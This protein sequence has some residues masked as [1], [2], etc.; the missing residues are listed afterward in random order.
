MKFLLLILLSF[1]AF[2]S[3]VIVREYE[4]FVQV[5]G[6]RNIAEDR[7][8]AM[9]KS[10]A[11]FKL[12]SELKK[13]VSVLHQ[14]SDGKVKSDIAVK[15]AAITGEELLNVVHVNT[16][17]IH[18]TKVVVRFSYRPVDLEEKARLIMKGK[19]L[20][21]ELAEEKRLTN[22][23]AKQVLSQN[24]V[25]RKVKPVTSGKRVHLEGLAEQVQQELTKKV[26]DRSGG[27]SNE[28]AEFIASYLPALR[29]SLEVTY[30]D[31]VP[32]VRGSKSYAVIDVVVSIPEKATALVDTINLLPDFYRTRNSS[33]LY[34]KGTSSKYFDKDTRDVLQPFDGQNLTNIELLDVGLHYFYGGHYEYLISNRVDQPTRCSNLRDVQDRDIR[35]T[36]HALGTDSSLFPWGFGS[37]TDEAGNKHYLDGIGA[38]VNCKGDML[39]IIT[40]ATLTGEVRF[41]LKWPEIG[42]GV[43]GRTSKPGVIY[44]SYRQ[45]YIVEM[46]LEEIAKLEN[47]ELVSW[48][49]GQDVTPRLFD[50]KLSYIEPKKYSEKKTYAETIEIAKSELKD[51]RIQNARAEESYPVKKLDA[52]FGLADVDRGDRNGHQLLFDL[53]NYDDSDDIIQTAYLNK[54]VPKRYQV[55]DK[56]PEA[57]VMVRLR[58]WDYDY[59]KDVTDKVFY[60]NDYKIFRMFQW[61]GKGVRGYEAR[62]HVHKDVMKRVNIVE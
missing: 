46:P 1:P 10:R 21:D 44:P 4:E 7:R 56:S 49:H 22:R 48:V 45:S 60:Y 34:E 28:G 3:D 41:M 23:V 50:K 2:S 42:L 14:I 25:D 20:K 36:R 47:L 11:R 30:Y 33:E 13:E 29:D 52:I 35:K 9:A 61:K 31:V 54:D 15:T 19:A 38:E 39:P 37:Y 53:N 32:I 55:A 17:K 27:V 62:K 57:P 16:G 12:A 40:A 26:A 6:Y 18:S 43:S 51:R 5:P 24:D 58:Y 8:I 59:S